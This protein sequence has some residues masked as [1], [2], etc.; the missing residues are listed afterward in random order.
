[1]TKE[2]LLIKINE[3]HAD[4]D[5]DLILLAYDFAEK[6][7]AGQK[8]ANGQDCTTHLLATAYHLAKLQ[9]D[10]HTI[11]AGLLHEV[12]DEARVTLEDVRAH[13]GD[14]VAFLVA[15]VSKLG[16]LKYR[17]I[18]RY[19]DNLRKLFVSVAD[20][21]RIILIKFADRLHN[22]ETLDALPPV[23]QMRI[24]REVLEIYVP[25]AH[26]LGIGT[27][28]SQLED[29]AFR[30]VYPDRYDLVSHMIEPEIQ[31]RQ[32]SLERICEEAKKALD[33]Q[34]IYPQRIDH[35]IKSLYSLYLKMVKKETMT[36]DGI[37]DVFA[38]RIVVNSVA[39]CYAALGIIHQLWK[40]ATGRIKD[41]IAQP[42]A[43]NYRSL[44]TTVTTDCG[45]TVEFQIQTREMFLEAKYGVAAHWHYTQSNKRSLKIQQNGDWLNEILSLQQK[46]QIERNHY[47]DSMKLDI[48]KN[49]IFVF[50]PKG[51][52]INLPE[53]A[54][55]I[56]FAYYIHSDVGRRYSGAK[57]NETMSSQD[58]QLKSGDVVEILV[59]KN[60]KKPSVHWL[61]TA[62]TNLARAKIKSQLKESEM[63]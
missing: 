4:S 55:P 41:Y 29:L 33:L 37:F 59:E 57:I 31:F 24:A 30:Y 6:A 15:G 26:R 25:I 46:R 51:D 12:T 17:G 60:R 49:R 10:D 9:M 28:K 54:T 62:K 13:F 20:D 7:H 47:L 21:I 45:D 61:D 48:F 19:A 40:P 5:H 3:Y 43:N 63:I 44:H 56:D 32:G 35:R 23:K 38:L 39:D 36:L 8:R 42:K 52:V 34:G 18:E 14:D 1:M 27:M 22:L 53:N 16:K 50:T 11:I 2:E 58:S